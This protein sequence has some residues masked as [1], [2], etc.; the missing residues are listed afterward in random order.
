MIFT[1]LYLWVNRLARIVFIEADVNFAFAF[2]HP[3]VWLLFVIDIQCLVKWSASSW[4]IEKVDCTL[5]IS[6][7]ISLF[8]VI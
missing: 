7:R 4:L 8:S 3:N 1:S 2:F 5:I 6:I